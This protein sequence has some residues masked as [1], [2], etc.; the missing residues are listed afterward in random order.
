MQD[1]LM[2][3]QRLQ[4][5]FNKLRNQPVQNYYLGNNSPPPQQNSNF[6]MQL[7]NEFAQTNEGKALLKEQEELYE[8]QRLAI[9]SFK[10]RKLNPGRAEQDKRIESMEAKL[11]FIYQAITGG[12][13]NATPNERKDSVQ[14]DTKN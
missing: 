6:D 13:I 5:E 8:R 11:E 4:E 10:V 2:E 9:E 14:Q 12:N 1:K 3:L 7:A